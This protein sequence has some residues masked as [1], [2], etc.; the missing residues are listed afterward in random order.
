MGYS[1][2]A[3]ANIRHGFAWTL[4]L[5]VTLLVLL[6]AGT[7]CS[8]RKRNPVP[9][10]AMAAARV[11]GMPDIR[12]WGG[13][14][15]PAFHDDLVR[16]A[17]QET[18]DELP[19]AEDGRVVYAALLISGGG[20]DGAFGAGFLNGWSE[21]GT[22]PVFKMVTG[23]SAG[24]LIAPFAFL[25]PQYDAVL[26]EAFTTIRSRD[27]YKTKAFPRESVASSK[28]LAGLIARFVDEELLAHVAAAHRRGRRLY[29]ATGNLDY[30]TISVWNMGRIAEYGGP[31]ALALFRNVMLAS[32]SIPVLMPPVMLEVEVDG[33]RYDEMHV[34]GG[35]F[36]QFFFMGATVDL[37]RLVEEAEPRGRYATGVVYV[38]RNGQIRPEPFQIKRG[39]GA[40]A[41][42]SIQSLVK[43]S[44]LGDLYRVQA[45]TRELDI[46][47]H[48]VGIPQGFETQDRTK[49]T[50]DPEI[51]RREFQLGYATAK[52]EDPWE[53]DLPGLGE[54]VEWGHP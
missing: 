17:A 52:S 12:A 42:R 5:G 43:S 8:A 47:F 28:P 45:M 20:A 54:L 19:R 32:A 18:G 33:A 49:V 25:G 4:V 37:L 2:R 22:R 23:I 15:S 31:E 11:P 53:Q 16:S 13:T 3:I 48:Y 7:G 26:E 50:F 38:I 36:A 14:V 29:V 30:Q 34:D 27:V 24:A 1:V 44:A 51:M 40:I 46:E 6:S 9:V 21:A 39:L 10:D 41:G 35:V